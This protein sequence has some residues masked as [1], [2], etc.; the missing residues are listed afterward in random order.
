MEEWG[1]KVLDEGELNGWELLW[2]VAVH[3]HGAL[4]AKESFFFTL[5]VRVRVCVCVRGTLIMV[6]YF[7]IQCTLQYPNLNYLN[8]PTN[9]IHSNLLCG[10]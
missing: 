8:F 9:D 3:E 1:Y 4:E 2:G 7:A 10:K 5:C 6:N